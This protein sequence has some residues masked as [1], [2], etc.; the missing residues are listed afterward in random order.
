MPEPSRTDDQEHERLRRL[1]D[2]QD[3]D[4]IRVMPGYQTHEHLLQIV[5]SLP[6]DFEP[7]GQR[8]RDNCDNFGDCSCG[9][10]WYHILAGRRGHDWGV[11]ACPESPRSGLL[12]FE[13]QGCPQFEDD[14][15]W[16]YL[17]SAGGQK[18]R[19]EFEDREEELRQWR[20]RSMPG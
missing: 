18:A 15:R 10:R 9:C 20:K 17:N 6:T 1:S 13:H 2:N 16:D 8:D 14:P 3:V 4:E 12:T 11:C 5:K 19:Q 7:W